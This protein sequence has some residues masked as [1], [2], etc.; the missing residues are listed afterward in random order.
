MNK[1]SKRKNDLRS[2]I[3][4]LLIL[5]LLLI[6][7]TYAWFTANQRVTISTLNVHIE[8]QNGLQ[9][10]TDG[11]TWKSIIE[12][13]DIT[14]NAYDGNTNIVPTNMIPVSTAGDVE[15]G[16]LKMFYGEVNADEADSGAYK[17]T[18]EQTEDANG[19]YIAFDVFLRVDKQT[20][21][22]MT[23][24]SNVIMNQNIAGNADRGIK[25][26]ARV[27]FCIEGTQ[28]AG[29]ALDTI[30]GMT[31]ATSAYIWEPNSNWH[32]DAAVAHARDNYATTT[33][34]DGNATA[35]TTHGIKADIET[36]VALNKSNANDNSTLFAAVTP[37]Y[38]TTSDEDGIMAAAKDIF[39]LEPGI[40]K[41]RVYMWIEGQDVDCEDRAS[42][43]QI[44][45]NLQFSI[46]AN[47]GS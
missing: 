45:Y 46:D 33:T 18:A 20:P 23:T 31:G 47:A 44:T 2:S 28:P 8:A 34:S 6:T 26:A 3:I 24:A 42:G 40:S 32:T 36:G 25:N 29:T 19:Q 7:S 38:V 12:N 5:L 41:V 39:T 37:N 1:K 22:V 4:L 16:L 15:G 30:T 9:I 21:L 17:L 35:L 11:T 14:E 13:T 43:G 27:A 10:S